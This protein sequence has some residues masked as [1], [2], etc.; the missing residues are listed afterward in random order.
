MAVLPNV[1]VKD[2]YGN[3]SLMN[4]TVSGW[5]EMEM[6]IKHVALDKMAH[7]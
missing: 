6:G 7:L 3:S 4:E 2:C 5:W 1:P